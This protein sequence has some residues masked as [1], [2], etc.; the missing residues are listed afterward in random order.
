MSTGSSGSACATPGPSTTIAIATIAIAASFLATPTSFVGSTGSVVARR[1]SSP[2]LVDNSRRTRCPLICCGAKVP[3]NP[4]LVSN[5]LV[6][7]VVQREQPG[8]APDVKDFATR[9]MA[10]TNVVGLRP[11]RSTR[12]PSPR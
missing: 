4:A 11:A 7:G 1:L 10:T 3:G 8:Q 12:S 2:P 9:S 5:A 6:Q